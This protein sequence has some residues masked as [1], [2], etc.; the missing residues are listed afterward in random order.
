MT[1]MVQPQQKKTSQ[2]APKIVS[3]TAQSAVHVTSQVVEKA[4]KTAASTL[5]TTHNSAKSV[6]NIG[7]DT[8]KEI[9]SNSTEEASK[10]HAKV[11]AF[12][13]DGAE[14]ISRTLD[15]VTRTL[16]DFIALNR[17]NIDVAVEVSNILT[18][19]TKA[20][21]TELVKYSNENFSENLD[22]CNEAF[23]CRNLNDAVELTNKWV[24]CNVENF[25]AQSER[26]AAMLFQFA[27]EA[28]EPVND[29]I[30]ESTE[31]LGKS[32]AA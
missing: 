1:V 20:T 2:V 21:N 19:I 17:E 25:F 16:N 3:K 6:V 23:S 18:D 15:A 31:R 4:A 5:E 9:F 32:L 12:G 22:I 14:V 11:F 10:A 7:A 30:L 29:H 27:N 13:R 24:S 26:L 8:M 28:S